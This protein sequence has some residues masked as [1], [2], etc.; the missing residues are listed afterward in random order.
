MTVQTA[1]A[2]YDIK[3]LALADEGK[4]RCQA[5]RTGKVVH[6]AAERDDSQV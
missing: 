2:K 6:T 5:E 3:D 4:R 1:P